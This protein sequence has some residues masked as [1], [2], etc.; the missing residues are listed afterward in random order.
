M[1]KVYRCGADEATMSPLPRTVLSAANQSK[2]ELI[3]YLPFPMKN[4]WTI[5]LNSE[6]KMW[7]TE[8]DKHEDKDILKVD[9]PV[10]DTQC[11]C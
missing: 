1:A 6:T 10:E 4:S 3:P 5:I 2:Q 7:G 11:A 9:V 8:H